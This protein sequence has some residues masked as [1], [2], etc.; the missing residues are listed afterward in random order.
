MPFRDQ[1]P[2]TTHPWL[3]PL[4]NAFKG[5]FRWSVPSGGSGIPNMLHIAPTAIA[6]VLIGSPSGVI[7]FYG[8]SG[9]PQLATGGNLGLLATNMGSSSF[10]GLAATGIGASGLYVHLGKLGINGGTGNV[11]TLNDIVAALKNNG[12]LLP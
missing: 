7:G 6:A 8:A 1:F 5:A 4:Y 2:R 10:S 11:Y 9:L 12:T 3:Q